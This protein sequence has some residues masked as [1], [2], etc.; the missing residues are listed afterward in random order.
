MHRDENYESD[1]FFVQ[2]QKIEAEDDPNDKEVPID[3]QI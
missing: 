3:K 2:S 1:N